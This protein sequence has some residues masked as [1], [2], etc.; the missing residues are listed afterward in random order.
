MCGG[1]ERRDEKS[2]IAAFLPLMN[3]ERERMKES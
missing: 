3:N 2:L 1:E